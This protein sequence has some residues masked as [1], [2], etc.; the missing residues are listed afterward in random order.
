MKLR[1]MFRNMFS[2]TRRQLDEMFESFDESFAEFDRQ[3]EEADRVAAEA[4]RTTTAAGPGET[5]TTRRKEVRPDGTRIVTTV[6]RSHIT[7]T[8]ERKS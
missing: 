1:S 7:V 3:F 4:E 8:K 5:V 2:D 6:T